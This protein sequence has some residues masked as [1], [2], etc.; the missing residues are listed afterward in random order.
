MSTLQIARRGVKAHALPVTR[1]VA[2]KA[3]PKQPTGLALEKACWLQVVLN[4]S[5]GERLDTDGIIG[6]LTR[7]AIRRLQARNALTVD[8]IVGPRT[9]AALIQAALNRIAL[10]SRVAVNGTMDAA[11]RAEIRRFQAAQGLAT[12]GIV[13]PKTRAAMVAALGGRCRLRPP[14]KRPGPRPG[15]GWVGGAKPPRMGCDQATFDLLKE[16]C[17]NDAI[18]AGLNCLTKFGVGVSEAAG[19]LNNLIELAAATSVIPGIN[20][21]SAVIAAFAAGYLGAS[22]LL[23]AAGCVENVIKNMLSCVEAARSSTRC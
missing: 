11:T 2:A 23:E 5:A 6:P 8:G 10:A 14:G 7:A 17:R 19:I 22:Q 12:D 15:Q 16:Q 1:G 20:V 4:T 9:D 13:G 3:A 21:I 18:Q